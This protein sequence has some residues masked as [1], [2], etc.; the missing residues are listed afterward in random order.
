MYISP[1]IISIIVVA[2]GVIIAFLSFKR[3]NIKDIRQDTKDSAVVST[4]LDFITQGVN[5]IQIK[6]ESQDSKFN[7]LSERIIRVEESSKQAHK[8]INDIE[9]IKRKEVL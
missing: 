6:I 1:P 9:Y 8:R 3:G 5:S 4:K 2:I 7:A